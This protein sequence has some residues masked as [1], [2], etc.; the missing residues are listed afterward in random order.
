MAREKMWYIGDGI[1]ALE[2]NE[3]VGKH[4]NINGRNGKVIENDAF[5]ITVEWNATDALSKKKTFSFSQLL[6]FL[7]GKPID[8]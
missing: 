1:R 8:A 6:R 2:T 3:M 4:V 7:V 5:A